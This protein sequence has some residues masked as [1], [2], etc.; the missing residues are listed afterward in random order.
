MW[1]NALPAAE[2]ITAIPGSYPGCVLQVL[3]IQRLRQR[4]PLI[5]F[6]FFL[7]L[8]VMLVGIACACL[9]DHPM[10]A[11]ERAL[12]AVSAAPAMI[13]VWTYAFAAMMLGALVGPRRFALGRASPQQLQRFLA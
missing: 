8:I 12:S 4:L 10:Q 6:I 2:H 9:T 3:S 1:G 13:E 11:V 5:V 7:V